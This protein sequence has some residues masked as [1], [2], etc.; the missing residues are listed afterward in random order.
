VTG[1]FVN[2]QL[3]IRYWSLGYLLRHNFRVADHRLG[4]QLYAVAV[5]PY[6]ELLS[7]GFDKR[8]HGV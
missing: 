7:C 4:T 1:L 2:R 6:H 5:Y 3:L 8:P